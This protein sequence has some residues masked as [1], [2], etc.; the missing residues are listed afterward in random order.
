MVLGQRIEPNTPLSGRVFFEHVI[1]DN[2]D[3][4]RPDQ[5]SLIFDRQIQ[6]GR[7]HPTPSR[8]RT[9]IITDGVTPSLH[10]DYKHTQIKQYHKDYADQL[11]M[12]NRAP[13][14]VDSRSKVA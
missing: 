1:R 12:P 5:V 14:A 10:V 11:A 8:F 3:T 7:R 2:L 4:G 13:E 6:R 9:R